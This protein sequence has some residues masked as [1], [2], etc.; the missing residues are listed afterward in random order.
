MKNCQKYDCY[1]HFVLNDRTWP[2]KVVTHAP[3]WG[4]VDLRDGNQALPVPMTI[5][6]KKIMF[7]HLVDIGFKHI[8]VGFPFATDTDYNFVRTLIEED[9]VPED[10]NI[11]VLSSSTKACIDKSFEALKGANNAAIQIYTLCS[12][13]QR[14]YV[15]HMSKNELVN[16][17]RDAA[18]YVKEMTKKY[19]DTN[20]IL[21]YGPESFTITEMDFALEV[22]NSVVDAWQPTPD[23]KC[24][25][26]LPSTVEVAMPNEFA[27][28]VEYINRNL[29]MRE[30]VILGIHPHNDR[31]TGIAAAELGLLAGA[32]RI[33]GTLFGNGERTGNVDLVT[34]ALNMYTTG[35]DPVIDLSNIEETKKIYEECTGLTIP[36]RQPYSGK[37][38]FT[39]YSGGHQDAIRKGL[40]HRERTKREKWLVPY[41]PIDPLDIGRNLDGVI[42][43]NAQSGKGGISYVLEKSLNITLPKSIQLEMCKYVKY[44]SDKSAQL[45]SEEQVL[46]L[47]QDKYNLRKIIQ[48]DLCVELSKKNNVVDTTIYWKGYTLRETGTDQTIFENCYEMLKKYY[49]LDNIQITEFSNYVDN[50][51]QFYTYIQI[52]D[53]DDILHEVYGWECDKNKSQITALVTAIEKVL[54]S[55]QVSD[56]LVEAYGV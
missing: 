25:I 17:T 14:K 46:E 7:Q 4:S 48:G 39:A 29:V 40:L 38:V 51:G 56:S 11:I 9:L 10:V 50:K 32:D 28:Q 33:E 27:D 37:Q 53:K 12:P 3:I 44:I 41:I 15:I 8:E 24:M 16:Y 30:N 31:G 1:D 26:T 36:I 43:I 35:I 19:S 6:K 13:A 47:F 23:N 55:Q 5:E 34:L 45:L 21:G 54:N 42:Q 18:L 20:F 2:S 22:C 49:Q 52:K